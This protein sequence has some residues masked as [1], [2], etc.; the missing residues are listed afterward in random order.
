MDAIR[1]LS[2]AVPFE[3]SRAR[4]FASA[5]AISNALLHRD[6]RSTYCPSPSSASGRILAPEV[7]CAHSSD[8][9]GTRVIFRCFDV[10]RS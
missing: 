3:I 8:N 4:T 6:R 10:P 5:V 7:T 2:W 9:D 1:F